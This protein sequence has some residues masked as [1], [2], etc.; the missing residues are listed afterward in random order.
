M[1]G[2]LFI[3]NQLQ[4]EKTHGCDMMKYT[5]VVSGKFER[6]V[7]RFIAEVFINGI[8]EQV[9]IKNT[10]RL[11]ELLKPGAR[12]FLERSRNPNRK[13]KYSLIAA[14]KNGHLVNIDSQAPNTVAFE[15]LRAGELTEFGLLN[16][17]KREVT[18]DTSRFDFY[19][20]K[21]EQKGFI[22]V[23]G[24]TLEKNGIA[25]F[26][27]APTSRGTKHV[28][29]LIDALH[30]G[31]TASI[32]FVVQMKD[33]RTFMPNRNMDKVFTEALVKASQEGVRIL[34][35]DSIVKEDEL[36]LDQPISVDLSYKV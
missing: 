7:N 13:T 2:S 5:N 32:L 15:A 17:L 33:T 20:E 24:V 10:G 35:Y 21:D 12:V 3:N 25:M 19:Y 6:R 30:E 16:T 36:V 23:K 34:A 11:K 4:C 9:H 29:E 8:K 14:A 27:D 22:E 18:Y 31:Y 1:E 26:P 28:L